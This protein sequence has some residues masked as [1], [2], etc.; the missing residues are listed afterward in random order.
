MRP[1]ARSGL[2]HRRAQLPS[3]LSDMR[4]SVIED[5]RRLLGERLGIERQAI[6][7]QVSAIAVQVE[8]Q[9]SLL[10]AMQQQL[11]RQH[12]L[13]DSSTVHGTPPAASPASPETALESA[14]APHT[15]SEEMEDVPKEVLDKTDVHAPLNPDAASFVPAVVTKAPV[16]MC[17]DHD[18]GSLVGVQNQTI[19]F[20]LGELYTRHA[21]YVA[22]AS[23]MQ[24]ADTKLG[25]FVSWAFRA[26][27][28]EYSPAVPPVVA[29]PKTISIADALGLEGA[30]KSLEEKVGLLRGSLGTA[31]QAPLDKRLGPLRQE[32]GVKATSHVVLC[33]PSAPSPRSSRAAAP[34]SSLSSPRAPAPSLPDGNSNA[35]RHANVRNLR[36]TLPTTRISG[37]CPDSKRMIDSK[38][39]SK[40]S[41]ART[42]QPDAHGIVWMIAEEI[43]ELKASSS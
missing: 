2:H 42:R 38:G 6:S 40:P 25:D 4:Q 41:R 39:N 22:L 15:L 20:L 3:M 1:G 11:E 23:C 18:V 21:R 32:L 10:L 24:E 27:S 5:M 8:A 34:V 29:K 28:E 17:S 33:P 37:E 7:V 26:L 16:S 43:D 30:V 13:I 35:T 19:S 36:A 12:N 9:Q 14:V 31:A